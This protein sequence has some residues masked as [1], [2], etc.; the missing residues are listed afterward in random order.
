MLL[1]LIYSIFFILMV[2]ALKLRSMYHRVLQLFN[3]N[4]TDE[5][6]ATLASYLQKTLTPDL[7][8]RRQGETTC[9]V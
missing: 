7:T 6:M 9:V 4:V 8:E 3:M 1:I 2:E 5:N